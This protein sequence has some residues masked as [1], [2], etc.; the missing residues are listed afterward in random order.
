MV[1]L[2]ENQKLKFKQLV[3]DYLKDKELQI[4][5]LDLDN[6][7]IEIG[8]TVLTL[9]N[10]FLEG[11]ISIEDFKTPL[12]S[13]NKKNELWGFRGMNGQ[14]FF[15]MLYNNS[16][17]KEELVTRLRDAIQIPNSL[18]EAKKK[19][20]DFQSYVKSIYLKIEDKRKGPNPKRI[21]YFTTYFWQI[22]NKDKFP[23][24]YTSSLAS[25]SP[26]G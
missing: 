9:L 25:Q 14:M 17:D 11:K 23:T 21:L 20:I 7:R 6:K 8:K 2:N 13:I 12:D 18:E 4:Q 16:K 26:L 1:I 15:N 10:K 5:D 24:F 19:I 22:Q 3:D